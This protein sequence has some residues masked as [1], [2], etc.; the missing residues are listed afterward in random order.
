MVT[1]TNGDKVVVSIPFFKGKEVEVELI[2]GI[3][4]F[5]GSNSVGKSLLI[6][7][8]VKDIVDF[9]IVKRVAY[10][11][12]DTVVFGDFKFNIHD[13]EAWRKLTAEP[14]PLMADT[15]LHHNIRWLTGVAYLHGGYALL[16][17]RQ[18][19]QHDVWIPITSL[20]YGERKVIAMLLVASM[21]D[22]IVVEGFEGGLHF[23][24]A[25][26]LL[27]TLED[28]KKH[29]IVETHMG[30]IITAGLKKGWNVYY[31]SRGGVVKLTKENI[32]ETS[33]FEEE[34]EALT[35]L[36]PPGP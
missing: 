5:Y 6:R 12:G 4:I 14:F 22:M 18:P 15:E 1:K 10:V 26:D 8:I 2:K 34:A 7:E 27:D 30:I 28:Y 36:I 13:A 20:S 23:D 17:A 25:I 24:T 3:N 33:L 11:M 29:V 32:L 31:V 16:L 19:G 35:N 21:A 9:G